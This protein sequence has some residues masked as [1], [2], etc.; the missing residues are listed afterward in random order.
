MAHSGG[1]EAPASTAG[2]GGVSGVLG[3][4]LSAYCV[5]ASQKIL[6]RWCFAFG[7]MAMKRICPRQA[8]SAPKKR[9]R[10]VR[11]RR[12]P[13]PPPLF[14]WSCP[15]FTLL[16]FG[17]NSDGTKLQDIT[18]FQGKKKILFPLVPPV[19]SF[20]ASQTCFWSLWGL[21]GATSCSI[22]RSW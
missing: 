9:N 21:G 3:L 11:Y 10:K 7:V 17:K 12:N 8:R 19:A 16:R 22:S 6:R 2:E 5:N 1:T 18:W 13:L 15:F 14:S 4:K 20:L